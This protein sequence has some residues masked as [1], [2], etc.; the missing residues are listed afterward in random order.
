M[1]QRAQVALC[2]S[3]E[4]GPAAGSSKNADSS[5][6]LRTVPNGSTSQQWN[7]P[8]GGQILSREQP[9]GCWTA[10]LC[11]QHLPQGF[12]GRGWRGRNNQR[13]SHC[14]KHGAM[15]SYIGSSAV[16]L[17]T[18][19]DLEHGPQTQ[20]LTETR[21][22]AQMGDMARCGCGGLERAGPSGREACPAPTL[23]PSA[24]LMGNLLDTVMG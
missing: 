23:L 7:R 11:G 3:A 22:T 20:M 6:V 9:R 8:L 21:Q 16:G 24:I 5:S 12:H 18:F 2:D 13:N 15:G 4:P 1:E 14:G 10:P 19:T 17:R